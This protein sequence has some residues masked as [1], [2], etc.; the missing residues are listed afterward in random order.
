VTLGGDL[1]LSTAGA[2]IEELLEECTESACHVVLDMSQVTFMDSTGL[3][4]LVKTDRRLSAIGRRLV[5]LR[6][7]PNVQRILEITELDQRLRVADS[8]SG[9]GALP[10]D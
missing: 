8:W 9:G 5:I 3:A 6:P 7:H 2:E 1:D 4:L 10:G